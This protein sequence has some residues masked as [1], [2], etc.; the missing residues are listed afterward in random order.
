MYVSLC[1]HVN[2]RPSHLSIH[3]QSTD[4]A[5]LTSNWLQ[6][7]KARLKTKNPS[8][9]KFHYSSLWPYPF[10]PTGHSLAEFL[11]MFFHVK[12]QRFK[13]A[14]SKTKKKKF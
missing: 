5:P 13:P 1:I 14:V 6:L 2:R 11:S 3:S 12:R 9:P 4:L 10:I 8:N 7:E